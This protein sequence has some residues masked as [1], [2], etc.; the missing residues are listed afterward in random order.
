MEF[1]QNKKGLVATLTVKISEEDYAAKVGKELRKLR[2]TTQVKGF[3]PGNVPMSLIKKMFE[4]NI[5][6]DE[7]NKILVEAINKYEKENRKSLIGQVIP[8]EQYSFTNADSHSQRTFEFVYEAGFYPEFVYQ[9]DHNIESPYYN[10]IVSE[11]DIDEEIDLFRGK[12]ASSKDVEIVG[13]NCDVSV[14]IKYEDEGEKKIFNSSFLVSHLSEEYKALFLGAKVNDEINVELC[15]LFSNDDYLHDFLGIDHETLASNQRPLSFTIIKISEK[16]P[17]VIDQEF[18][19]LLTG[20]DNVHSIEELRELLRD[21]ISLEYQRM[22]L[23]KLYVDSIEQIKKGAD[24]QLPDDF[25]IRYL[26]LSQKENEQ[27]S[28]SD[29]ASMS[30]AFIETTKLKFILNSVL[31]QYNVI[32]TSI[33]LKEEA[34][35]YFRKKGYYYPNMDE[36]LDYYLNDGEFVTYVFDRVKIK[37][38][39]EILK[40]N[41]KLSVIDTNFNDFCKSYGSS[42]D[43]KTFVDNLVK[44]KSIKDEIAIDTAAIENSETDNQE[45]NNIEIEEQS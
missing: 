42:D 36:V 29:F 20:K 6:F 25:I 38:F 11:E 7:V 43:N 21:K 34:K 12:Y 1:I 18:F 28:D 24:I 13:D 3:R 17:A 32:I 2:Q 27:V 30:K 39:S 22:S 5:V 26:R 45:N 15:N 9:I 16:L 8:C 44:E 4:Q 31:Q 37:K 40:N 41:I 33:M 19:D 10:I 23:D 35:D 14:D